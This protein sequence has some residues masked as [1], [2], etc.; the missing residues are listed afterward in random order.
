MNILYKRTHSDILGIIASSLCLIHCLFT[1]FLFI[2]HTGS[3][4]YQDGYSVLWKSLDIVFLALSFIAIHRS[5]KTT[6][7]P[8]IKYAFW[9]SWVL[10]LCIIV[11]EKLSLF[12]LF[13]E[14]IYIVSILLVGLHFYNKKY[15][16][17]KREKCCAN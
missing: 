3:V 6:T 14:V 12:P 8:T 4:L 10:L 7:N 15:C 13:E 9:T 1:P 2:A 11:N 16:G 5:T 17:C